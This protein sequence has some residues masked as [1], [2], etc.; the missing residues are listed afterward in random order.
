MKP[1]QLHNKKVLVVGLGVTGWSVVRYLQAN[2]IEFAVA[3]QKAD[4]AALG[5]IQLYTEFDEAVFS[6]MDIIVLSPGVP[7]SLPAIAAAV[8]AGTKV[9]GDIELFA[10][11][12][13][14]P[15]IAS[16]QCCAAT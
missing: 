16:M 11:A 3:E 12:V 8:N 14:Q 10:S 13:T 9:I 15:V 4:H 2:D 7:R 1:A 5:D 6:A